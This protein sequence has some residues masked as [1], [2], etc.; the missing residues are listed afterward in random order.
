MTW[1]EVESCGGGCSV[2]DGGRFGYRRIGLP[3]SGAL[4]ILALAMA[5][6]V[7]GNA[8]ASAGLELIMSGAALRVIG[9]PVRVAFAGAHSLVTI[10]GLPLPQQTSR[11]AFS[12]QLIS[13]GCPQRGV[14]VVLAV[15]GGIRSAKVLGSQSL[16]LRSGIGGHAGRQ[17]RAG[18]RLTVDRANLDR[19]DVWLPYQQAL[20]QDSVRVVLG[21][22][23]EQFSEEARRLFL[24]SGYV[25]TPFSDRMA[26]RLEGVKIERDPDHVMISDG[27]FEGA[28]Q[29][30]S[31]GQPIVMLADHQT[32]GG[33]PKIAGVIGP[34]LRKVVNSRP[35]TTIRFCA[36]TLDEAHRECRA[37]KSLLDGLAI[38]TK[39]V[40]RGGEEVVR[41]LEDIRD[42][43]VNA[44]DPVSWHMA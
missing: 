24:D 27:A 1:L 14:C 6:V 41:H 23:S 40:I 39:P 20:A 19:G 37:F 29:I 8:A 32:I 11:L 15:E 10:D 35:G 13:V 34:D 2:Q 44:V 5:N 21:P 9:G 38:T 30:T 12:G 4:D 31:G 7:V 43:S 3:R 18:D 28:I 33:Y 42:A 25:V 26:Y 16:H 17:L 22:Q 36:V